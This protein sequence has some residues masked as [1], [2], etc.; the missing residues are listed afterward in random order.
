ML[1]EL[2]AVVRRVTDGASQTCGGTSERFYFRRMVMCLVLELEKP[3]LYLPVHIHVDIDAAG[4][5]LLAYL[6]V[7]QKAF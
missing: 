7:I 4:I 3:F 1:A 5:V 6:H 2:G